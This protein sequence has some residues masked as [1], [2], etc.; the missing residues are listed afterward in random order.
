MSFCSRFV[1]RMHIEKNDQEPAV[2]WEHSYT[3][4]SAHFNWKQNQ[5]TIAQALIC[6]PPP[7]QQIFNLIESLIAGKH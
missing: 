1:G 7:H 5:H 3:A 4:I 2:R 6:F